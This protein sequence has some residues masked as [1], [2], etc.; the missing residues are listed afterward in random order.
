[1][2]VAFEN[3]EKTVLI[4]A[5]PTDKEKSYALTCD[6]LVAVTDNEKNLEESRVH[7]GESIAISPESVTTVVFSK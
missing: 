4:I 5:N 6:A 1:M 2:L 3:E 7:A